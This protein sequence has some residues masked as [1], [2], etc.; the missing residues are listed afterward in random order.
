METPAEPKRY[1]LALGEVSEADFGASY[2]VFH[3]QSF[4]RGFGAKFEARGSKIQYFA[5]YHLPK[6]QPT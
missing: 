1:E 5:P 2:T 6:T 4:N 3:A